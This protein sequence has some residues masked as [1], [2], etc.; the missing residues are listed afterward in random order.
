MASNST[1]SFSFKLEDGADG[2]KKLTLDAGNLKKVMGAVVTEAEALEKPFINFAAFSTGIDSLNSSLNHL[3]AV[4]KELTGAYQI[5]KTAE[6]QLETV[7]RQRMDA[8]DEEI[9]SIKKLAS[10][11]QALG[12][13]GDE[14]QLSGAQQMATF[15]SEKQSIDILLPAMNNLLAQQKGLNATNQDAVNIGNLMG[16][17][18]QGQT[19]ALRRVGITFSEAQEKQMKFGTESERAAVLAQIITQ[20]VGEMNAKL[21]QTD[22]GKQK[23]L[24]N[25]IGDIKELMGALLQGITPYLTIV[26]STTTA[27][28]GVIKLIKGIKIAIATMARWHLKTKLVSGTM[29]VLRVSAKS[30]AAGILHMSRAMNIGVSAATTL[31]S[32]LFGLQLVTGVGIAFAATAAIISYFSNETD[33]AADSVDK[34]TEAEKK[35]KQEAEEAEAARK[36][37]TSAMEHSRAALEIHIAKIKAFRGTKEQEKNLINEL[38]TAYGQSMGYFS[39]LSS[40]YKALTANSQTYTKQL[41]IQARTQ[42][43]ADKVAKLEKENHDIVYK[44]N[45]ADKKNYNTYREPYPEYSKPHVEK[46]P[47]GGVI[48]TPRKFKGI[49]YKP[50]EHDKQQA[51]YNENLAKIARIRDIIANGETELANLSFPVSGSPTPPSTGGDAATSSNRE[52]TRLEEINEALRKNTELY[53]AADDARKKELQTEN[54]ALIKEKARIELSQKESVRPLELKTEQ[55][56]SRELEY[57]NALSATADAETAKSTRARIAD[58][59]KLL[60]ARRNVNEDTPKTETDIAKLDTIGKLNKALEY[61]RTKQDKATDDEL[62]NNARIMAAYEKKIKILNRGADIASM[63]NEVEDI[64]GLS[65]KEYKITVKGMG[66]DALT[67]KINSIQSV[68]DDTKNPVSDEQRKSLLKLQESYIK[69]RKDSVDTFGA[70]RSGWDGVKGIGGGIQGI[71]DALEGNGNAWQ[72]VT[73]IID[74]GLQIYDGIMAVVGMIQLLTAATATN[75]GAKT[76]NAAASDASV[77][78]EASEA[79]MAFGAAAA[80]APLI[81]ANKAATASYLELAAAAYYATYASIPILGPGIASGFVTSSVATV[82][83]IGAMAFADGGIVSG[84]TLGLIGEYAGARNNPEVVAPLDKLRELITPAGSPVIVGGTIRARGRDIECVLANETRIG[85]R[86]GRRSLLNK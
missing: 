72:M 51:K 56:I 28:T 39:T 26:A 83:S 1:I 42:I 81:T 71:S 84:P 78:A 4:S 48:Y 20:N 65:D 38:N 69:M 79:G 62:L 31:R 63:E 8:T 15:L 44:E 21:A 61:Y 33:E 18:M 35:A 47:S 52:K 16:K 85:R 7:M 77:A 46:S 36:A 49:A 64:M 30:T 25:T 9:E 45:S 27:G 80:K 54:D 17:A 5:Q 3:L 32:V 66:F 40:W 19:S 11:Q 22:V 2:L 68:L 23:Q 43:W 60:D 12:T 55:D 82:K 74:S 53:A 59:N 76:A 6:T 34:L 50:S 86:S 10:A 41:M 58:L 75:T 70:M 13:I 14:V 29:M 57:Q 24:E 67:D 73:G 37:E